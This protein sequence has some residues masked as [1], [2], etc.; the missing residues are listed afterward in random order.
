MARFHSARRC[1]TGTEKPLRVLDE[2]G[3]SYSYEQSGEIRPQCS[4]NMDDVGVTNRNEGLF[5]RR[6]L[7]LVQ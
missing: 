5:C 7:T 4:D 3:V 1:Y 2:Y 6:Q